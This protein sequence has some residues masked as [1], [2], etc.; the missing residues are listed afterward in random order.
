MQL[1]KFMAVVALFTGAAVAV[2]A[3]QIVK[4]ED[5][6]A[7]TENPEPAIPPSTPLKRADDYVDEDQE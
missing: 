3:P 6:E 1:I 4:L 5:L 2:A 7:R